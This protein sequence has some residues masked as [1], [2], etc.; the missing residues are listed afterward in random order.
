MARKSWQ[1]SVTSLHV[2]G[3][4]TSICHTVKM[5]QRE[6]GTGEARRPLTKLRALKKMLLK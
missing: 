6:G 2:K 4:K 5:V 3:R 1:Q